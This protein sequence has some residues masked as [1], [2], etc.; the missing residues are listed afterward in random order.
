MTSVFGQIE[1]IS[2]SA[3][4]RFLGFVTVA[5][6]LTLNAYAVDKKSI[7]EDSQIGET[8]RIKSELILKLHVK[9]GKLENM[10]KGTDGL[11]VNY[12]IVGGYFEGKGMKGIVIPGGADM[13]VEREDGV[14]YINALYRIKTDD[15]EIIIV[16]NS[17]IWRLNERGLQKKAQGIAEKDLTYKDYYAR[18]VPVFKTQPG[19]YSWLT[20]YVFVGTDDDAAEDEVLI[21]VYQVLGD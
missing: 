5:G 3:K 10:G 18:T 4:K 21:S 16:N 13:S 12:P 2:R 19:K 1:K 8:S 14:V 7:G 20:D 9:I 15:G 17:G 6:L 11:R